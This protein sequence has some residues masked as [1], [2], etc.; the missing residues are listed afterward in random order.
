LTAK[1]W[2]VSA[3][4]SEYIEHYHHERNHQGIENR[5]ITP[6]GRAQS[7]VGEVERR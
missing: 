5:L 1:S 6:D 3:T 2:A 4:I 7:G